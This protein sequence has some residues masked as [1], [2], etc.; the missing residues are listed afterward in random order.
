MKL[1]FAIFCLM[2]LGLAHA[3]LEGDIESSGGDSF[4]PKHVDG[5]NTAVGGGGAFGHTKTNRL[6]PAVPP[7]KIVYEGMSLES[8]VLVAKNT[9][10]RQEALATPGF[11]IA[12]EFDFSNGA[13][14]VKAER[15]L[16]VAED[17]RSWQSLTKA[18]DGILLLGRV[19]SADAAGITLEYL[20]LD[21]NRDD[22][23]LSTPT[24]ILKF[25]QKATMTL[26]NSRDRISITVL[27]TPTG[28]AAS[29]EK[30]SASVTR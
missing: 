1:V 18:R 11:S 30:A 8:G 12:T 27:A 29:S 14:K 23:V 10:K 7:T 16:L 3:Q 5:V 21:T 17:S 24:M 9:P 15:S 2:P 20:V 19:V 25:G 28:S 22:F 4:Q 13:K 6:L 26:D